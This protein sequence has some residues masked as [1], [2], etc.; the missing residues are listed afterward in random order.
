M[1]SNK[2]Q[3]CVQLVHVGDYRNPCLCMTIGGSYNTILGT[4]IV[5]ILGTDVLLLYAI[6]SVLGILKTTP[7]NTDP[8]VSGSFFLIICSKFNKRYPRKNC[9]GCCSDLLGRKLL[10]I[11]A[12]FIPTKIKWQEL[13]RIHRRLNLF[14]TSRWR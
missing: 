4:Q 14:E 7:V 8:R 11:K 5:F 6:I 13:R 3:K 2:R 10:N 1:S 12:S 9:F